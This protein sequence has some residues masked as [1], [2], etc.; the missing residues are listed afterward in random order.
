MSLHN[1]V[2]Q[3]ICQ[4]FLDRCEKDQNKK[5]VGMVFSF[6]LRI[7]YDKEDGYRWTDLALYAADNYVS[8]F[9]RTRSHTIS[10]E[11]LEFNDDGDGCPKSG[12]DY[13]KTISEWKLLSCHDW[14]DAVEN[15]IFENRN[16]VQSLASETIVSGKNSWSYSQNTGLHQTLNG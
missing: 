10:L 4:T 1:L 13:V 12:K 14:R 15:F 8:V 6:S 9:S 3:M 5:S 16:V 7:D 2:T 11:D